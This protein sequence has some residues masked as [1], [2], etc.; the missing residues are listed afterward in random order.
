[1]SEKNKIRIYVPQN[2]APDME[3]TLPPEQSHYLCNVM[4]LGSGKIIRCFNENNGEFLAKIIEANKKQTLLQILS[5]EQ[6]PQKSPDIWL[7]FAPLKK[8]RT[9]FLVEKAVEL[10]VNKIIPVFTRFGITDKIRSDRVKA[11]LVEAVEQC[12][13]FDVPTLDEISDLNSLLKNWPQS[14]KLFFMDEARTGL[15]AVDAFDACKNQPAALLI[16]PE[17]G[18]APEEASLLRRLPFVCPVSLGPRIL[19]AET[20]ATA[21]LAVWQAVAGDWKE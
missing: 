20:A 9:D 18:F 15:P 3:I 5:L 1:M 16:G 19:R 17:G 21:A 8:D 4:R 14:R 7:V 2:L 6:L 12:E 11:Q 13:R 10:G